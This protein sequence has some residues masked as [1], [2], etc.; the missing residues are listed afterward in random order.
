MSN[1]RYGVAGNQFRTSIRRGFWGACHLRFGMPPGDRFTF[2]MEARSISQSAQWTESNQNSLE[3]FLRLPITRRKDQECGAIVGFYPRHRRC[4]TS[5][6][7]DRQPT[8]IQRFG[9]T[10]FAYFT[11]SKGTQKKSWLTWIYHQPVY[12][13]T[14]VRTYFYSITHMI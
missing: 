14:R 13:L 5:K 12:I 4:Y 2:W 6:C 9:I 8:R 3:K 11:N 1:S 7:L 10:F